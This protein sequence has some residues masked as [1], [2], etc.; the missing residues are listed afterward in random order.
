MIGTGLMATPMANVRIA[1]MP[2]PIVDS[3]P[4][5][6]TSLVTPDVVDGVGVAMARGTGQEARTQPELDESVFLRWCRDGELYPLRHEDGAE[7]GP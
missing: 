2:C 1:S 6:V 5:A 4:Y 7:L 3:V